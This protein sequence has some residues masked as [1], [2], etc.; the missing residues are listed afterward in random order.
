MSAVA[1]ICAL[2]P[3]ILVIECIICSHQYQYWHQSRRLETKT[4]LISETIL[5]YFSSTLKAE[6][7][8]NQLDGQRLRRKTDDCADM[9]Y[10]LLRPVSIRVLSADFSVHML[11]AI[12]QYPRD[13]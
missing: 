3:P 9:R 6:T 4:A 7:I 12:P 13:L 8:V 5:R 10:I 2:L 1:S 11:V